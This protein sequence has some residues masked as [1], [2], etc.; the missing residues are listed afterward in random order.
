MYTG[1]KENIQEIPGRWK[2]EKKD[3]YKTN[4]HVSKVN[5]PPLRIEEL[6]I[7]EVSKRLKQLVHDPAF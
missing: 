2:A 7:E 3:D 1:K 4:V 5:D 6:S